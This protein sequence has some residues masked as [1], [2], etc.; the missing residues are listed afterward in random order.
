MIGEYI[1]GEVGADLMG[2]RRE[3]FKA[4]YERDVAVDGY[5]APRI[6]EMH[7]GILPSIARI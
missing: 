2:E 4:G 6:E 3:G 7:E 5:P 1:E